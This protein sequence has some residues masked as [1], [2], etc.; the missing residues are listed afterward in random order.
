[1]LFKTLDKMTGRLEARGKGYFLD[2]QGGRGFQYLVGVFKARP[3]KEAV[4]GFVQIAQK[5]T[6]QMTGSHAGMP[7]DFTDGYRPVEI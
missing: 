6:V 2:F 1:M 7:G 3:H 5:E 4:R